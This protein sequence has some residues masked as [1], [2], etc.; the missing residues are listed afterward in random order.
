MTDREKLLRRIKALLDKT[1]ASGCPVDE[2][3]AALAKAKEL[4]EEY[5]VSD[6]ELASIG[7]SSFAHRQ[8]SQSSPPP[9]SRPAASQYKPW[10]PRAVG[11]WIVFF[12]LVASVSVGV[13][14]MSDSNPTP[15][16]P[17]SQSSAEEDTKGRDAARKQEAAPPLNPIVKQASPAP[18]T[19]GLTPAYNSGQRFSEGPGD[20]PAPESAPPVRNKFAP[21]A[22]E[23]VSSDGTCR[24][25]YHEV[26]WINR[27]HCWRCPSDYSWDEQ[28]QKCRLGT[29]FRAEA[30]PSGNADCNNDHWCPPLVPKEASER[31]IPAGL[32]LMMQGFSKFGGD[33]EYLQTMAY[34]YTANVTYYGKVTSRE[35]VLEDKRKFLAKWP[36]RLFSIRPGSLA[37]ACTPVGDICNATG[38]ADFTVSSDVK[39]IV[40][41]AEFKYQM[42]IRG[43]G[44]FITSED[45]KVLDRYYEIV[46]ADGSSCPDGYEAILH[47][48]AGQLY[49]RQR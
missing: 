40:G 1:V 16:A 33:E 43:A 34:V 15:S 3:L 10:S 48:R 8:Q 42:E 25:G 20:E 11:G 31:R 35:N 2:A 21:P 22:D 47:H 30:P 24:P 32:D 14:Q 39:Q 5:G 7:V 13:W 4:I 45:G 41:N 27:L 17:P 28:N 12:A 18:E 6:A 49:C 38:I 23:Y 37:V 29:A 9:T 46:S 36:S 19:R 44:A 26:P